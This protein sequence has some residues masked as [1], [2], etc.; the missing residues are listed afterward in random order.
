MVEKQKESNSFHRAKLQEAY[1]AASETIKKLEKRGRK[2]EASGTGDADS[3]LEK[4]Q[5]SLEILKDQVHTN[6]AGITSMFVAL[7]LYIDMHSG[8]I[9]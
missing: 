9:I 2:L 8:S 5:A 6:S 1:R 3:D 7:S 4:A